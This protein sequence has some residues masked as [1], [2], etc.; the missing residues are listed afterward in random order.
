M[1][2]A[3]RF[4]FWAPPDPTSARIGRA[5]EVFAA[6]VRLGCGAV[7]SVIPL[8]E[9]FKGTRDP[10]AWLGLSYALVMMLLGLG[11]LVAVRLP[12]PPRWLGAFTSV[13]DVSLVSALHVALLAGGVEPARIL[14]S[15]TGYSL[16]FLALAFTWMRQD[17][18]L[19]VL[20]GLTAVTEY[21]AMIGWLGLLDSRGHIA[22]MVLLAAAAA[23]GVAIVN[24]SRSY[25]RELSRL[26]EERTRDLQQEKARAE[27]ASQA[28][29]EFLANMSHEIRTPLNAVLG[30]TSLVLRSPLA[31]EQKAQLELVRQSGEALLV[32]INDVLDVS[33]IEAGELE[34]ELA[35]F[36]LRDCIGEALSLVA[37]KASGKGIAVGCHLGEELP[38]AVETDAGRL[39]QILVNLLDNA[40]KFTERGEVRLEVAASP[41]AEGDSVE[42]SFTVRDTGIGIP[43]A[44]LKRLFQPFVQADSSTSRRYGGTGLGLVIS[45]RLAE[46]LGGRLWVESEPGRGSAFFFTIRCRPALGVPAP[47]AEPAHLESLAQRLPWRILVAEDNPVNQSVVVLLLEHMGYRADVAGD[48]FEVLQALQRQSYDL[49]LMDVQMPGMDGLETTRRLRAEVPVERQPR[50]IALTASVL[51]EQRAACFAAGM[52]D[53]LGKPLGVAEL[54]AALLRAAGES[55]PDTPAPASAASPRAG[56]EDAEPLLDPARLDDLVRLETITGKPL[57]RGIV[58]TFLTET[59]QRLERMREAL[60]RADAEELAFVAHSLK[61]SSSQIGALRLT[62]LS[63]ELEMASRQGHLEAAP[64]LLSALDHELGRVAP[65]LEERAVASR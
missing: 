24:Q 8:G 35:P 36:S 54:Q 6:W 52:D 29:S 30:L 51:A 63:A 33:K 43:A 23:V 5:G 31:A 59:P 46:R 53:F 62:T 17:L 32:V 13:A 11:V 37:Q 40:V 44:A 28:K 45:R 61:G 20:G 3:A 56:T 26:V 47:A 16:Y 9:I 2:L 34:L 64:A 7:G 19:C 27:A 65:L 22:R 58:D 12:R 48:G 25:L 4:S 21:G 57:V 39:R 50:I 18:R 41:G 10:G 15:V 60:G 55:A 38:D 49:I 1:G 14:S 42:L